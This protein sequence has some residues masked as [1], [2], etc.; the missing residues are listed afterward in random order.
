MSLANSSRLRLE[1]GKIKRRAM[2]FGRN[3]FRRSPARELKAD[4]IIM[5]REDNIIEEIVEDSNI[6]DAIKTVL[7]KRRRKRSFAGVEYWRMSRRR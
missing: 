1:R 7:R 5:W 4:L 2:G 3:F 6:E